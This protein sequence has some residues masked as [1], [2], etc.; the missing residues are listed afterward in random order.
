MSSKKIMRPDIT[1]AKHLISAPTDS[2]LFGRTEMWGMPCPVQA[3]INSSMAISQ[4]QNTFSRRLRLKAS[5]NPLTRYQG[6][7]TA[8][9]IF[10]ISAITKA[11]IIISKRLRDM[12]RAQSA[13]GQKNDFLSEVDFQ[14]DLL[15]CTGWS[16]APTNKASQIRMSVVVT[17]LKSLRFMG[18]AMLT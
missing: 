5:M 9:S 10:E 15:F 8:G 7:L 13:D 4:P 18:P 16:A 17:G 12:K 6:S 2:G 14:K 1:S 3:D 11:D